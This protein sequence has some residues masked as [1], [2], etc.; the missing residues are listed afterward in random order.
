VNNDQLWY[1][2]LVTKV[3]RIGIG[4]GGIRPSGEIPAGGPESGQG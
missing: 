1:T 2:A 3:W 4:Q